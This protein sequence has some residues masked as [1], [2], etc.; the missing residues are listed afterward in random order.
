[1]SLSA[2]DSQEL[3]SIEDELALSDPGLARLLNG[4]STMMAGQAM[5]AVERVGAARRRAAGR[6][7]RWLPA[8]TCR[9]RGYGRAGWLPAALV[10][11]LVLICTIVVAALTA[12]HVGVSRGCVAAV[13]AHCGTQQP[14]ER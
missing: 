4:F 14:L 7:G 12:S 1:M 10:L 3:S 11:S 2:G 6:L 13:P 8:L 9:H 5:P